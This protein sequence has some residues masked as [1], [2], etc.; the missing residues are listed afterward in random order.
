MKALWLSILFLI[1]GLSAHADRIPAYNDDYCVDDVIHYV[2]MR[3]GTEAQITKLFHVN[4][5]ITLTHYFYFHVDRCEGDII[6]VYRGEGWQCVHP[7]YG[8]RVQFLNHVYTLSESC[9]QF[10]PYDEYPD[11][12]PE[13]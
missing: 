4:G 1:S 13:S 10:I 6:A 8:K 5:S 11:L 2:E 3:F 12:Y 9:K 7:Q